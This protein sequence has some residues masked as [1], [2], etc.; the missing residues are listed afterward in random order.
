MSRG[1]SG[2]FLPRLGLSPPATEPYSA[3]MKK[4][5][6]V[7]L[8]CLSSIVAVYL[9]VLLVA[10]LSPSVNDSD[11]RLSR[12]ALAPEENGFPAL[13]SAASKMW[14]PEAKRPELSQLASETNWNAALATEVLAQNQPAL[15]ALDAALATPGF[16]VPEFR[17]DDKL[18][19]LADFRQLAQLAVIRGNVLFRQGQEQKAIEQAL[20]IIRLGNRIEDA[21]GALIHY[22]VGAAVKVQGLTQLRRWAGRA[23]LTPPQLAELAAQVKTTSDDGDALA[24]SLKVE[25]QCA[26]QNLADLR[27]GKLN[28][29]DTA[30]L[31]T[32]KFL[33]VFNQGKTKR[34]YADATRAIIAALAVPYSEAKLPNLSA[35]RPSPAQ[36]ILSGNLAGQVF[37]YMT[38]PALEGA[39][40]SQ[41]RG[42]VQVEA[43]RAILA[44]RAY[45]L[46][47]GRLPDDLAAL[48]PEFL[49]AVPT[50]RFNGQL[51][52]YAP[53]RKLIYSVGENLHD[54]NG[55][56]KG[57]RDV[58][59]DYP[60]SF[61]F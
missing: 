15:A 58:R 51:L 40:K 56:A 44:L 54:D 60:F 37:F 34:L 9:V 53:E 11:L 2:G 8:I 47:H 23:H 59:L 19:Y 3:A 55:E 20:N 39:A 35:T 30:P 26:V 21:R 28:N 22:L 48:S 36:L 16:Q 29:Q 24:N 46:K 50:D 43:T 13:Q 10:G 25:Y 49:D 45:Q 17:W 1:G 41:A 32:W 12:Q 4:S 38:M 33:P 6:K 57:E 7:A 18:S 27:A 61:D 42:R 52:R 14:W 5:H 31:I